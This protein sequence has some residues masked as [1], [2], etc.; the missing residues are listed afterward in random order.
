MMIPELDSAVQE[1]RLLFDAMAALL[2]RSDTLLMV[3]TN[4]EYPPASGTALGL[5]VHGRSWS[6]VA[7][8][9]LAPIS[10]INLML[11]TAKRPQDGFNASYC[12]GFGASHH[13]ERAQQ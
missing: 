5:V 2:V 7:F 8:I 12:G 3:I 13:V 10:Q 6:A 9:I 1:L 4:N 11:S